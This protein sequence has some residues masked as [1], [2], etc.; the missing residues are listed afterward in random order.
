MPAGWDTG[1]GAGGYR[2]LSGLAGRATLPLRWERVAPLGEAAA[3]CSAR[4]HGADSGSP[5][6]MSAEPEAE[7]EGTAPARLLHLLGTADAGLPWWYSG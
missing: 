3:T 2:P 5:A 6:A 7:M 1:S 4:L